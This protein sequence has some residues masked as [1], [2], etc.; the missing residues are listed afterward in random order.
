M[1]SERMPVAKL[2][3]RSFRYTRIWNA[4]RLVD[5]DRFCQHSSVTDADEKCSMA[6]V[7]DVSTSYAVFKSVINKTL[8][9]LN[10][11]HVECLSK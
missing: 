6:A 3:K 5:S 4:L 1:E 9:V 8:K 10:F 2:N 7:R 11:S